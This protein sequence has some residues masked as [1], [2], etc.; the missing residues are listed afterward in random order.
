MVK[1]SYQHLANELGHKKS[2]ILESITPMIT[3]H[4][5]KFTLKEYTLIKLT[6]LTN[7]VLKIVIP[8]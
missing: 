8:A 2:K 5:E 1:Y 3:N 4:F 6:S 7:D